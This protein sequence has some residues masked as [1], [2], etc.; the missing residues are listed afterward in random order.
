MGKE[1]ALNNKRS[2]LVQDLTESDTVKRRNRPGK[3]RPRQ[4]ENNSQCVNEKLSRKIIDQALKQ[5]DDLQAEYVGASFSKRK[6]SLLVT[7]TSHED[8]VKAKFDVDDSSEEEDF[9]EREEQYYEDVHVDEE[10]EK[11]LEMFM[12]KE[13][14]Q[15]QTLADIIME[16]I[17]DKK[18][19]IESQMSEQ[20]LAP[21]PMDE[22]LVKVFTGVGDILSNYRSGKLPKAFKIIPSLKNWEEVVYITHPENWT[23]AAMYQATRI[24]VS[25]FN[26]KLAQRFFNLILLPRVRDDIAEYKRL[27]YHLYQALMK[28]LFK[29]AAFF[30]GILLPLCESGT[31]T[32]REAIIMGSVV[33]KTSIPVLHASA[34]MLKLAEMYYSGANSILLRLLLD[35]KYALPYRVIDA[36]VFHFLR[37]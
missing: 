34:A 35:K 12:S 7:K 26:A 21:A 8:V 15:R 36:V 6:K 13:P 9:S 27:N 31:C 11:A 28:A 20:S 37:F 3:E 19:E 32:L 17:K 24:F 5:Q 18:T 14:P 23:A 25:N 4:S 10:D 29:P 16:K 30:K 1:K 33:T 22:R 2:N